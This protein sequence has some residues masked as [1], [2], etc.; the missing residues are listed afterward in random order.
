MTLQ[1]DERWSISKTLK[2][3][4]EKDGVKSNLIASYASQKN[5]IPKLSDG[6]IVKSENSIMKE[7]C[8]F[9]LYWVVP[10]ETAVYVQNRLHSET[11]V[12][13]ETKA[14][15]ALYKL[16]KSQ[17]SDKTYVNVLGSVTSIIVSNNWWKEDQ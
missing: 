4:L 16:Y 2:T 3:G 5:G 1:H 8:Y 6:T 11:I 14:S 9:F 17:N 12:Y 10:I 15:I 13:N 7:T